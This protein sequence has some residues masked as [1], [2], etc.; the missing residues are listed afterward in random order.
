M[1]RTKRRDREGSP[2][3]ALIGHPA[4]PSWSFRLGVCIGDSDWSLDGPAARG[5]GAKSRAAEGWV[6]DKHTDVRIRPQI[7]HVGTMGIIV[8]AHWRIQRSPIERALSS[9]TVIQ[10]KLSTNAASNYKG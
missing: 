6:Y 10:L 2:T 8:L 5:F 9:P 4:S 1:L 3:P 7:Y